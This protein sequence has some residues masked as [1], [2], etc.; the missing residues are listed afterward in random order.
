MLVMCYY[1]YTVQRHE[2]RCC[3]NGDIEN[4][5]III[6]IIVEE[7]V[8]LRYAHVIDALTLR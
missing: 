4:I 3:W 6:I 5:I 1:N 7:L 8:R 2:Q